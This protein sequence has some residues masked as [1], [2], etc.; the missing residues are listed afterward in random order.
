MSNDEHNKV[1]KILEIGANIGIIV[2]ALAALTIFVK[3]HWLK[4]PQVKQ[5]SVGE[6]FALKNTNW[7]ASGGALVFGISTTCHFCTESAP[8]Y[9]ELVQ[10]CTAQHVHTIAVLPQS[11]QEAESYLSGEGILV[12][13]IRQYPLSELE[14]AGTP[15]L[16]RID[17]NGIV[18]QMWIGKLQPNQEKDVLAKLGS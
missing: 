13:E 1:A 7:Q 5:I 9:R 10:R 11:R 18:K 12:D 15:T 17:A 16:L 3:D 2:F 8:F 4:Q 6:P 14:I